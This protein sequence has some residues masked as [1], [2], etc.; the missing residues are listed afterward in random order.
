M[1]EKNYMSGCQ[2]R[3]YLHILSLIHISEPTRHK[4]TSRMPSSA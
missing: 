2:I 4:W 3:Q 1:A